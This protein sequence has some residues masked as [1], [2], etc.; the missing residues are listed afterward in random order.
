M[1]MEAQ[2]TRNVFLDNRIIR[3]GV[4]AGGNDPD[5]LLGELHAV[6]LDIDVADR[7]AFRQQAGEASARN[8]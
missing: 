7:R 2:S 4:D 1:R 3:G 5:P 6:D 8:Q